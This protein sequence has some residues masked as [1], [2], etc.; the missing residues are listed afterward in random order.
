MTLTA[1]KVMELILRAIT[2]SMLCGIIGFMI[3]FL[4]VWFMALVMIIQFIFGTMS[5]SP[6][7]G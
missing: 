5:G 3:Y 6:W 2:F 1:G 7:N 4:V